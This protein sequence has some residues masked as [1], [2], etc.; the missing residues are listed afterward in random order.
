MYGPDPGMIF[1]N[2]DL[3][4]ADLQVM[5]WEASD[6]LLKAALKRKVDIHLL[7]VYVL[8]AKEPPPLEELVESHP[9]YWDHRGPRKHKREFAKVFCHATDYLGKARTVAAHTGRT[10]QETERA[11]RIYLGTYKGIAQ[12]QARIIE[13]VKKRRYVEN[14]FGYRWY[15]FDRIDDQIMPEAM[16][17]IPQSTV[18]IVI[19]K[20][21][22]NIYQ[23]EKE[24]QVLLQ[25]HD[26]LA[27]QFPAGRKDPCVQA[28]LEQSK[29]VVPYDD[30]L[31]IPFTVE[32]SEVSWGACK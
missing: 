30:P 1:F 18:S 23:N 10:I 31:I 21:W 8:D 5:A 2:G 17:W 29:V 13:E 6:E 22:H 28:I 12:M 27:G 11:Q 20:I 25:V 19:N 24:I 7:N 15:I 26:S 9:K 16:A 3:D 4:R 14:R 32:T